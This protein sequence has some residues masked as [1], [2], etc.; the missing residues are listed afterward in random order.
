MDMME[1]KG[2]ST[3]A[4]RNRKRR[5]YAAAN[6]SRSMIFASEDAP[7][8]FAC[9]AM[10]LAF[11]DVAEEDDDAYRRF[12]NEQYEERIKQQEL[13]EMSVRKR[14]MRERRAGI[15]GKVVEEIE[16]VD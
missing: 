3:S 6:R 1:K 2:I 14:Y 13:R 7:N 9:C 12:Q 15:T 16:V 4:I 5:R 11:G 8:L 10:G